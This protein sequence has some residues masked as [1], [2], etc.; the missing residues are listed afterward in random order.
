MKLLL[1]TTN[2]GKVRE[3]K[4]QLPEL[5]G[6]TLDALAHRPAAPDETGATFRDNAVLK[7]RYYATHSGLWTLADDS[8][9]EVDALGGAPGVYSARYAG[10]GASDADNNRK[11]LAALRTQRGARFRCV[12][13]LA[14]PQGEVV[15]CFEGSCEGHIAEAPSGEGGF[16]YDPIFVPIGRAQSL[17]TLTPEEKA[18]ISH[19]GEALRQLAQWWHDAGA[20]LCAKDA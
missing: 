17:A 12:L 9:L 5:E 2:A 19:R 11:L 18:A 14:N 3:L 8:G 6:V 20:A 13:A 16:G 10:E 1:A 15:R 7:A 4:G